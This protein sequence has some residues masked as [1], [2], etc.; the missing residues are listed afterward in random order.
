LVGIFRRD[1]ALAGEHHGV[2]LGGGDIVAVEPPVD[3]DRGVDLFHDGVGLQRE[4]PAPHLVGH[5]ATEL[6]PRMT[7]SADTTQGR[8]LRRRV[9]IAAVAFAGVL[10]GVAAVYGIG[11]LTRNPVE[12]AC[13]SASE[14][15]RRM[16]PLSRGEVAAVTIASAPRR[17]PDL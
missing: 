4:A 11:A 6:V 14:T 3:V 8:S 12:T 15:A 2:C 7:A 10:A 13:R 1:D 9:L 5:D 16:A 17:L